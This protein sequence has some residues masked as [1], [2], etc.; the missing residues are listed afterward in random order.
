MS[1]NTDSKLFKMFTDNSFKCKCG[2]SVF[3]PKNKFYK[4]CNWCGKPV[5]KNEKDEFKYNIR[6]RLKK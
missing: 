3:I 4:L 1:Y 6:K 2:H 5:F